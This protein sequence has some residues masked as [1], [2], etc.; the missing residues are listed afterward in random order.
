M[1][2]SVDRSGTAARICIDRSLGAHELATLVAQLAAAR[3]QLHPGV[4]KS[5]KPNPA[6]VSRYD[7]V[8][9]TAGDG[10]C[11]FSIRHPGYGWIRCDIPLIALVSLADVFKRAISNQ[12][13]GPLVFAFDAARAE[14]EDD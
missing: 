9:R 10:S 6:D 3:S 4:A 13:E 1:S 7:F 12:D 2:V 14:S 5:P 11:E 8:A